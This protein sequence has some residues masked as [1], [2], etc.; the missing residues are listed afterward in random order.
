[1]CCCNILATGSLR[2]FQNNPGTLYTTCQFC[3][4][5]EFWMRFLLYQPQLMRGGKEKKKS[6][7][8]FSDFE[9]L[10]FLEMGHHSAYSESGLTL[11][12]A[13]KLTQEGSKNC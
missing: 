5:G 9:I 3:V 8:T 10:A 4:L 6:Y 13:L 1:M 2:H 12:K 7:D 11:L